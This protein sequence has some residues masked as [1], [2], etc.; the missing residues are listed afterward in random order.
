MAIPLLHSRNRLQFL[1]TSGLNV[2][3][4]AIPTIALMTS[5]ANIFGT[6]LNT[7]IVETREKATTMMG[8]S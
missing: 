5:L 1:G 2:H 8:V 7:M 4:D 3:A 6:T